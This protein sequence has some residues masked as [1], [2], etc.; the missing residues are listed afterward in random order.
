MHH[1]LHGDQEC[2]TK[3]GKETQHLVGEKGDAPH[4]SALVNAE[5]TVGALYTTSSMQHICI[6]GNSAMLGKA[7]PVC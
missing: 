5:G 4:W 1:G 3:I 6:I 7:V 2:P